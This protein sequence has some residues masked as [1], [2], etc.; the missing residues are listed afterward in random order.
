MCRSQMWLW[1]WCECY[2]VSSSIL[3]WC[4]L[5]H[6][7]QLDL[8]LDPLFLDPLSTSELTDPAAIGSVVNIDGNASD[9]GNPG[10]TVAAL[11]LARMLARSITDSSRTGSKH[12][13]THSHSPRAGLEA[14]KRHSSTGNTAVIADKCMFSA[15]M[16]D[17]LGFIV[18][19]FSLGFGALRADVRRT[20]TRARAPPP[21]SSTATSQSQQSHRNISWNKY[22]GLYDFMKYYIWGLYQSASK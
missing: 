1:E 22:D 21:R 8:I 13:L 20:E 15:W 3:S 7:C 12:C 4:V 16:M 14:H 17:G 5:A 6:M 10:I 2:G 18:Y 9:S 11:A 19:S